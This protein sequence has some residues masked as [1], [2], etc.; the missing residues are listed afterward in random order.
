[1]RIGR[2]S[3]TCVTKYKKSVNQGIRFAPTIQP[4]ALTF[5]SY[6][7]RGVIASVIKRLAHRSPNVQLYSLSLAESLSKNC[8]VDLHRE[9]ASRAFTQA[10]EKLVTDRVR[11]LRVQSREYAF[12]ICSLQT[13]HDKVRKRALNLIAVWTAEFEKDPSLGVMEECYNNLKTKSGA[14]SVSF[15]SVTDLYQRL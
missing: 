15:P 7:A 14:S 3:S 9:L 13:T 6:R 1:M 2:S 11:T 8:G 4:A 12:M 10:L 5:C